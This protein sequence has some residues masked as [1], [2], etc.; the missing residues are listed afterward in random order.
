MRVDAALHSQWYAYINSGG[1][2]CERVSKHW[3]L[4]LGNGGKCEREVVE[5][6]QILPPTGANGFTAE[7]TRS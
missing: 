5:N 1:S 3:C 2:G 6:K 7:L 4:V